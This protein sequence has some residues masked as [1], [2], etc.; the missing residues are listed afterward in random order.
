MGR[1]IKWET[2][3]NE[4]IRYRVWILQ[5]LP[6]TFTVVARLIL[7]WKIADFFFVT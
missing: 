1:T 6:K 2:Y 4:Q 3:K 5:N 7:L